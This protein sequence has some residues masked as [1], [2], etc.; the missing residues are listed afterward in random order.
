LFVYDIIAPFRPRR[1]KRVSSRSRKVEA[2]TPRSRPGRRPWQA[3]G[4]DPPETG[5]PGDRTKRRD[6][7]SPAGRAFRRRKK[8]P[9]GWAPTSSSSHKGPAVREL[10]KNP[11]LHLDALP[12]YAPELNPIEGLWALAKGHLAN[13]CPADATELLEDLLEALYAVARSPSRIHP[14]VR[15]RPFFHVTVALFIRH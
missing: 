6:D 7:P 13:G 15:P 14:A 1:R 2:A 8:T 4:L 12:P 3:T 10:C 9:S 5:A 11:R